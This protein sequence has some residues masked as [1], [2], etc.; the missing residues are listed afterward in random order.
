MIK[1]NNKINIKP[2]I[3]VINLHLPCAQKIT[4]LQKWNQQGI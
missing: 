2:E 4:F 1:T 3:P